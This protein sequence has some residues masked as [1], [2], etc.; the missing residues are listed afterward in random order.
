MKMIGV[1]YYYTLLII[2]IGR[3]GWM[4]D[5]YTKLFDVR[6]EAD[7]VDVVVNLPTSPVNCWSKIPYLST[8]NQLG[9]EWVEA[10]PMHFP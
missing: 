9:S 7:V 10:G 5:A 4:S 2:R 3:V 1:A 8:L 6:T